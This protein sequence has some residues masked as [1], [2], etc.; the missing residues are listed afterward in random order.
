[1]FSGFK[2]IKK[3]SSSSYSFEESYNKLKFLIRNVSDEEWFSIVDNLHFSYDPSDHI[4][5]EC[6]AIVLCEKYMAKDKALTNWWTSKH[7]F[8]RANSSRL[9]EVTTIKEYDDLIAEGIEKNHCIRE[10][11]EL[12][13]KY[14]ISS[15]LP[16]SILSTIHST[17][18]SVETYVQ[19][20]DEWESR[21]HFT[22]FFFNP[23]WA[24]IIGLVLVLGGLFMLYANYGY[25]QDYLKFSASGWQFSESAKW[26]LSIWK[27]TKLFAFIFIIHGGLNIV[28]P[29]ILKRKNCD[30]IFWVIA[31]IFKYTNHIA[32]IFF[33]I[34]V[35]T[36][37]LFEVYIHG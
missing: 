6:V 20:D 16:P 37:R 32:L 11:L 22:F 10:R 21:Y 19:A 26:N 4:A 34:S 31:D 30:E 13:N 35:L 12:R 15:Q 2:N 3:L 33:A 23:N 24:P 8:L 25:Y 18:K 28:L 27:D 36:G 7:N 29:H 9:Y 5:V 14:R 17:K 1:M